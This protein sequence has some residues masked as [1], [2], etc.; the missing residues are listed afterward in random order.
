MTDMERDP[1]MDPVIARVRGTLRS[2]ARA[3]T[4]PQAVGRLLQAVWAAP[5]PSLWR[6]AVEAFRS[7]ALSGL[8]ASA[9]AAAALVIG[10]VSRG[11]VTPRTATEP[12][13]AAGPAT[14][15]YPVT[16]AANEGGEV[17]VATQFVF[18]SSTAR[19]VAVVGEFNGWDG[20][21]LPMT[22]VTPGVWEA[23]LPLPPGRHVYAYLIDGTLLV[24]DPRA[25]KSGDEDYGR[26]GSVV[27]VFAR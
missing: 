11:A 10:F 4:D 17:R 15:E 23:T 27:M 20:S 26:E 6:R 5:R 2:D 14:G 22:Q 21:A 16:L 1:E 3:A 24:A 19:S 9:L 25:P 7:P 18:E 12:T 13:P 8:S